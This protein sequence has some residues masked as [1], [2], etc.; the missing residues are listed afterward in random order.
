MFSFGDLSIWFWSQGQ[1]AGRWQLRACWHGPQQCRSVAAAAEREACR[2]AGLLPS[3]LAP[4][5]C[6]PPVWE[7]ALWLHSHSRADVKQA[8]H[9]YKMSQ[10]HGIFQA[11]PELDPYFQ[12]LFSKSLS[13][14]KGKSGD[15]VGS[16]M[17]ETNGLSACIF[18]S[19]VSYPSCWGKKRVRQIQKR[20]SPSYYATSFSSICDNKHQVKLHRTLCHPLRW[21]EKSK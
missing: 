5:W 2:E 6:T 19:Q 18:P 3:S 12:S 11:A 14:F 8:W 21:G 4:S 9:Q 13:E 7:Q 16:D 10:Q 17:C 1:E 15:L 20:N